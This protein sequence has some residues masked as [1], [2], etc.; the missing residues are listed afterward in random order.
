MNSRPE[1][2]RSSCKAPGRYR[3]RQ[4]DGRNVP[5][6]DVKGDR[7]EVKGNNF[8][9]TTKGAVSRGT[10]KLDA[11]STPG[12]LDMTFTEGPEKGNSYLGIFQVDG[13][14]LKLCR[15]DFGKERPTVF[16][17]KA[18]GGHVL[19]TLKRKAEK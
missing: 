12:T 18:G 9:M 8:N 1:S 19:E 17:G 2:I 3:Q 14:K 5:A 15:A 10:F 16:A 11:V 6:E 13:D 7:I 4:I